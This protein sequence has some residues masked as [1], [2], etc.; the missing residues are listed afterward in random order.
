MKNILFLFC[1]IALFFSKPALA[2]E[3]LAAAKKEGKWG[4]I[5]ERGQ[6][7]I[8][9][10][11]DNVM[12]FKDGLA[13]VNQGYH[14]DHTS[15]E[16][17]NPGKWGFIDKE[18]NWVIKPQFE[19]VESFQEGLAKVNIGAMY[20][21]YQGIKLMGGKWGFLDKNGKWFIQPN[22][23]LFTNFS[24]GLCA[25]KIPRGS[26]WGYIDKSGKPAFEEV[27]WE[28]GP[29]KGGLAAVMKDDFSYMYINKSGNQV[30]DKT[31]KKAYAFN[32][33]RAF[34]KEKDGL[35]VVIG[36][37]AE[38]FFKIENLK[39]DEN[40]KLEFSEG[41]MKIPVETNEG[42]KYGFAEKSGKWKIQPTYE[43]ADDFHEGLALV[44]TDRYY[45]F[46]DQSGKTI[47]EVKD[48]Y[49]QN[50]ETKVI[51]KAIPHPHIGHFSHGYCKVNDGAK[52]GF[53]DKEGKV[54]IEPQFEDLKEFTSTF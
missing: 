49:V 33:E 32:E 26:R 53:L 20:R 16:K 14:F 13:A 21:S 36:P 17:S 23:T 7:V 2:Q 43:L 11:F 22:D 50:P 24:E 27:F 35:P 28:V 3:Y 40:I 39:K 38:Y 34:V 44:F 41:L 45:K 52:W 29:F 5:N 1:L 37:G 48:I 18:G 54:A 31:F 46:I 51:F 30:F 9:A 10:V 6:F 4:F 19:A 12:P 15:A 25:F 8:P 42:I 47:I